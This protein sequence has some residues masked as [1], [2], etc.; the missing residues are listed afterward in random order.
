MAVLLPIVLSSGCNGRSI[1]EDNPVFTAA[2]P[3]RSLVNSEADMEEQRLVEQQERAGKDVL[4][5]GH[6]RLSSGPLTGS[7]VVARSMVVRCFWM[8]FL[9]AFVKLSRMIREFLVKLNSRC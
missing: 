9:A 3:R 8:T 4:Q 7:S 5:A 2:P 1:K 6:S